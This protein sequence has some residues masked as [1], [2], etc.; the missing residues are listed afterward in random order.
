MTKVAE[1]KKPSFVFRHFL[2]ALS[3]LF[4]A[5]YVPLMAREWFALRS[6]GL[7]DIEW[8]SSSLAKLLERDLGVHLPLTEV[9]SRLDDPRNFKDVDDHIR[10]KIGFLGLDKVKIFT[11]DGA[12]L[13]P[14]EPGMA[15]KK[16]D[17]NFMAAL[18]GGIVSELI[19]PDK[20]RREYGQGIPGDLAEVYL[21]I[22]D[23]EGRVL[24][25]IEA[26]YQISEIMEMNRA[27]LW[28]HAITLAVVL[29][30]LLAVGGYFYR[31]RQS[32]EKKV[33]VLESIL[34]IC[35]YC[36]KIRVDRPGEPNRWIAVEE[37]FRRKDAVEFSHGLCND[38][39]KLHY[40]GVEVPGHKGQA[41]RA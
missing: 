14:R 33:E 16:P 22:R 13:Y 4:V 3:G 29:A 26:Y 1:K 17:D 32:L 21:P 28:Q 27:R 41:P 11:R 9:F 25:V 8:H 35:M 24:F 7:R 12:L 6:E 31:S 15:R 18:R 19:Q 39:L 36:K 37:F 5:L 20:Y 38:C 30:A 2:V 40:P 10:Q 34:P 23:R